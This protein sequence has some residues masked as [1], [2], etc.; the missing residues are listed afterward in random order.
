MSTAYDDNQGDGQFGSGS[1]RDLALVE[2]EL[3]CDDGDTRR[4]ASFANRP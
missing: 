1:N 3:L 4:L 2:M